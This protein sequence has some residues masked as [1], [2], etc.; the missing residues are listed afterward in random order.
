MGVDEA[1][2]GQ[3][4]MAPDLFE[5]LLPAEDLVRVGGEQHK[6]PE[7]GLRERQHLAPF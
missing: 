3:E 7:L 6:Q 4:V 2:V 5:Q 1:A